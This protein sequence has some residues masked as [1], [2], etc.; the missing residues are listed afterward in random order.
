MVTR[1]RRAVPKGQKSKKTELQMALEYIISYGWMLLIVAALIFFFFYLDG[2]I[3]L[4]PKAALGQ[5][6]PALS[7][8]WH[9][10]SREPNWREG[11]IQTRLKRGAKAPLRS[12]VEHGQVS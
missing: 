1:R 9:G 8:K 5:C 2:S 10:L 3:N 12:K 4:N 7:C 11:D 6:G